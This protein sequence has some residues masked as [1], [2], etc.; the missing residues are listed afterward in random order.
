VQQG[1][2]PRISRSATPLRARQEPPPLRSKRLRRT[3]PGVG[4]SDAQV[5]ELANASWAAAFEAGD[6]AGDEEEAMVCN[7]LERGLAWAHRVFDELILLATSVS[8]LV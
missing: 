4:S 6:D 1:P 3:P 7:T 5:L 8:F 2:P